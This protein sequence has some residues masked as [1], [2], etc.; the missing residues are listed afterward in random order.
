M[1]QQKILS[2]DKKMYY[3]II[4][5]SQYEIQAA[6]IKI[7]DIEE[8]QKEICIS[9]KHEPEVVYRDLYDKIWGCKIC[10]IEF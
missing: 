1:E 10:G 4:Q 7:D 9:L 6:R 3:K 2:D 8:Q 5:D